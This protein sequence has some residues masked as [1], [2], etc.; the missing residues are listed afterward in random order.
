MGEA[1]EVASV[2]IE[3]VDEQKGGH[4]GST[5]RKK[6]SHLKN[7]EFERKYQKYK[8]RVVLLGDI[9]KDDSGSYAVFT[10]QG[11]SVSQMAAA[12]V[13]DAIAK[14]LNCPGQVAGAVSAYTQVKMEDTPKLL[15]IPKSQCPDVWIRLPRQ[16]WPKSWSNIEDPVV[17][18]ERYLYGHPLAGLSNSKCLFVH[19]KQGLFLSAHVDD[20]GTHM[21]E[22]DEICRTWRTNITS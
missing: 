16:K 9:V 7:A 3:Q 2:A 6:E 17:P 21:E 10:G 20:N 15:K 12:K 22:T 13:L 19:R 14:L 4:S 18:L 5:K 1:R 8:G 11:S